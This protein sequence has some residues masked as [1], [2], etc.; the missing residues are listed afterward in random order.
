[1]TNPIE[2]QFI[3]AERLLR[4][5]FKSQNPISLTISGPSGFGKSTLVRRLCDK[6]DIPWSP[7][8]ASAKG[9]VKCLHVLHQHKNLMP[10]IF[11]DFDDVFTDAAL[12]EFF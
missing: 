3:V 8:R 7:I 12:L 11:D 5:L 1:V 9:L 2:Q 4:S 6:Y 10:L